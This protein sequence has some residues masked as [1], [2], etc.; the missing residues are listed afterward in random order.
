M[1]TIKEI[2]ELVKE[3]GALNIIAVWFLY[4]KLQPVLKSVKDSIAH[5]DNA[6]NNRNPEE[7]TLSQEVTIIRKELAGFKL[8][9][10]GILKDFKALKKEG[11]IVA[12]G[13]K[14]DIEHVNKNIKQVSKASGQMIREVKRD[15][16][17]IK[18]EI[19]QHRQVD[20]KTF[21]KLAEDINKIAKK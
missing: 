21:K 17:Y 5:V 10:L 2:L 8:E 6:V 12:D 7:V 19:D 18:E 16:D 1:E 15:I 3:Y 4:T 14:A 11:Y 9:G 13:L 20:E